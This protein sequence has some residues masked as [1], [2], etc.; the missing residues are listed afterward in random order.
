MS[1]TNVDVANATLYANQRVRL[2]LINRLHAKYPHLISHCRYEVRAADPVVDYFFPRVLQ[3][4]AIVTNAFITEKLCE[5]LSG[6]FAGPRGECKSSDEPYNYWVGDDLKYETACTPACF[7]LLN[8]PTFDEDGSELIQMTRLRWHKNQCVFVSAAAI[9][10][11]S[12]IF[13]SNEIYETRVN[14]LPLGFN[15]RPNPIAVSGLGYTFNRTYCESFFD[16]WNGTECITPWYRQI[17]NVVVGESIVK[18]VQAGVTAVVN[19][20]NTIPAPNMPPIPPVDEKFKLTNWLKDI[21]ETFVIPDPDADATELINIRPQQELNGF[22]HRMRSKLAD[23]T[24]PV[25]SDDT[26][27][28]DGIFSP[29]F[30]N[31]TSDSVVQLI[32]SIF[33]DPWFLYSIGVDVLVDGLLDAVKLAAK[34]VIQLA[35]PT[36]IRLLNTLTSP[37]YSRVFAIAFRS[38]VTKMIVTV[39]LRTATRFLVVLARMAV[40]ASSV[41]GIILIIIS[42]FDIILSFWDPLGFG[43]KYP[44]EFLN[45]MMQQSDAA[46]R[47]DFQMT[48]PRLIFDA[49]PFI[50]LTEEELVEASFTSFIWMFEYFNS[51]EVNSEG[52]R[53]FRGREITLD[54]SRANESMN[55]SN[56]RLVIPTRTDFFNFE[57]DH[58][59]R[60]RIS[61]FAHYVALG[62]MVAAGVLIAFKMALP[63]ILLLVVAF[64]VYFVSQYNLTEDFV[65]DNIPTEIKR[66]WFS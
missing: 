42:V 54:A 34:R 36:M 20:G 32:E 46:L 14:D 47:Q 1:Y 55:L 48:E 52:S 13:R 57:I 35:T 16:T 39:S 44:P 22:Y 62:L 19:N 5:K 33:T 59:N 31:L 29:T 11:E 21:D 9:W 3:N 23:M 58:L 24:V 7:N 37:M 63:A 28:E 60:W 6:N 51:L 56:L 50:L 66:R 61:Q 53:I 64:L 15:Y 43:Q 18:L 10:S 12:P 45:L 27:D 40:L 25:P 26:F 49:L 8:D 17:L 38:T 41:I 65:L 2:L 30:A 4:R